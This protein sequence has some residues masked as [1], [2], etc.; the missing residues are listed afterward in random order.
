MHASVTAAAYELHYVP[1]AHAQALARTF[2][3]TVGVIVHDTSDPYY[4]EILRG[5]QRSATD[6]GHLLYAIPSVIHS[7]NWSMCT[8]CRHRASRRSSWQAAILMIAPTAD[9]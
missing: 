6:A 4:A 5:V 3:Q 2:T 7:A 9:L 8:R 1:D